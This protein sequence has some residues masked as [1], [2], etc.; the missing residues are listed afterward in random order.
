MKKPVNIVPMWSAEAGREVETIWPSIGETQITAARSREW[1]GL[2]PARYGNTVEHVFHGRVKK[3]GN[4]EDGE[5]TVSYPEW[6]EVT[7]YRMIAGERR[8]FTE[9]VYW[10]EAYGRMGGSALPNAMWSK[11]PFGQVAK[12][13]KAASLRAA[14]PEELA[15]PTDEEVSGGTIEEAQTLEP[16]HR[17]LPPIAAPATAPASPS[18]VGPDAAV[19]PHDPDTGEI[20]ETAPPTQDVAAGSLTTIE[21]GE[22]MGWAE[23]GRL[24]IAL[25]RE[26]TQLAGLEAVMADNAETFERMRETMPKM[27]GGLERTINQHKLTLLPLSTKS[28]PG[29]L[30]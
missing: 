19:P 23:W 7:V 1:A 27:H 3:R 6:C 26:Q 17:S 20:L 10:V 22:G 18:P 4:W 12:V 14:F 25:V 28:E 5:A 24:F 21:L 16:A 15:T 11:R 29:P 30:Q 8:P 13:A 9:R 2:D